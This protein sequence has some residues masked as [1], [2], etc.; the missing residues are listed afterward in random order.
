MRFSVKELFFRLILSLLLI[1]IT[2]C[3]SATQTAPA[4]E[5]KEATPAENP[6]EEPTE[7]PKEAPTQIPTRVPPKTPTNVPPERPEPTATAEPSQP[8]NPT[9]IKKEPYDS[10][11]IWAITP[12]YLEF[13]L[14]EMTVEKVDDYFS[15]GSCFFTEP[16]PLQ[17]KLHIVFN[18]QDYVATKTDDSS[19]WIAMDKPDDGLP[20]GF[21]IEPI[22]RITFYSEIDPLIPTQNENQPLTAASMFLAKMNCSKNPDSPYYSTTNFFIGGDRSYYSNDAGLTYIGPEHSS[23]KAKKKAFVLIVDLRP[24]S[25][26]PDEKGAEQQRTPVYLYEY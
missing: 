12:D 26:G 1:F 8:E 13:S 11:G 10:V 3:M 2:S 20:E 21:F 6:I 7:T 16:D 24:Q 22:M 9:D 4:V 17:N 15:K 18:E 23:N 19:C 14:S 25:L 5:E